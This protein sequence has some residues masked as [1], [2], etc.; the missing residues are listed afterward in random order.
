M[1]YYDGFNSINFSNAVEFRDD[2]T[3]IVDGVS[4]AYGDVY[5]GYEIVINGANLGFGQQTILVDSVSC[6]VV[7]SNDSQISCRVG[8]RY[9]LPSVNT[10][11]VTVGTCK[12]QIKKGFVYISK[13]SDLRT[14][15][16]N[17]APIDGDVVQVPAGMTLF[18]DQDTP[19]LEGIMVS[20]GTL[21]F[22]NETDVTVRAKYI[23]LNGGRFIAGTQ[24]NPLQSNLQFIMHG[25]NY[26]QQQSLFGNKGIGC[27]NCTFSMFGVPRKPV[28]TTIA[29][30]INPGDANMTVS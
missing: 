29:L 17:L 19:L 27:L 24:E 18:V 11:T 10:F 3:P 20:N 1:S 26:D 4:P 13:W 15:A 23:T 7:A 14:W 21:M 25:G 9:V 8:A 16:Q 28:W 12:A 22:S 2:R 30:T 6:I 5:G